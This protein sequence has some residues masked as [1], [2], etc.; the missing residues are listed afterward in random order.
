MYPEQ[1][2]QRLSQIM[3]RRHQQREN[4]DR[5]PKFSE[6]CRSTLKKIVSKNHRTT[7]SKVTA[8]LN[9]HLKTLFP[10][11]QFESELHKSN[12][13]GRDAFDNF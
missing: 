3:G 5:K 2:F 9:F 8:E 1:Q 12:I 6:S 10:Q 7:A 11:K 13:H 4:S